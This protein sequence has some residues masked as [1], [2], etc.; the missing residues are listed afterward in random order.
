MIIY[1]LANCV[2][3]PKTCEMC[4]C[5]FTQISGSSTTF[6]SKKCFLDAKKI[7]KV[8]P[9]CNKEF[10]VLLCYK[11]KVCCTQKC[12]HEFRKNTAVTTKYSCNCSNCGIEFLKHACFKNRSKNEFCSR[13]CYM[14]WHKML[15]QTGECPSCGK[16]VFIPDKRK[17]KIK[18]CSR[19]CYKKS[20]VGK[21]FHNKYKK[22]K[23]R[24]EKNGKITLV[25]Y[26]SS[27]EYRRMKE[28]DHDESI[29]SWSRCKDKI[30]WSEISGKTHYYNP[31]FDIL[32]K[33]GERVVEEIKGYYNAEAQFKIEAAKDYYAKINV[34][35]R[36][37]DNEA[38]F[39]NEL[40]IHTD[41]YENDYGIHIRPSYEFIW[42]SAAI[43]FSKR[44]T[45]LRNKV[46][47]VI[48][49]ESMQRV[50]CFG[51]NGDIPDGSNQC[52]SLKEGV[53]GCIHAEINAIT[54]S[55]ESLVGAHLFT[56]VAPCINCA[57]ILLSRG[58]KRVI[59]Q[60]A[61][62]DTSGIRLLRKNG[63]EILK[64]NDMILFDMNCEMQ[65]IAKSTQK[66]KSLEHHCAS[67]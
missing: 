12:A 11:D 38:L 33:N 6:C 41:E 25:Y 24:S 53:C 17:S 14:L 4:E 63:V 21:N 56:T 64:Y 52:E 23:Y 47:A 31:D 43:Q 57:K 7:I 27:W 54:K 13:E 2:V 28:L 8:C 3:R 18:H 66:Q 61:Y 39:D 22:S 32:Y 46:G 34:V 10:Q 35:F 50:L 9:N 20:F 15:G 19:E 37:L 49:D 48:T 67:I 26:D 16:D 60:R 44:S 29:V 42:M 45:C 65:E 40:I 36:V 55:H 1:N 58:I 5:V 30:K 62:R 51:Y 59:F